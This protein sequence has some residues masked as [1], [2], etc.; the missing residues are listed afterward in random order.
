MQAGGLKVDEDLHVGRQLTDSNAGI[1]V[2]SA[3]MDRLPTITDLSAPAGSATS[4]LRNSRPPALPLFF[5]FSHKSP[6]I[7][8]RFDLCQ[9]RTGPLS[10]SAAGQKM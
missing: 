2:G 8:S 5:F 7:T 9:S 3:A 4:N 6:Q 1:P 10:E